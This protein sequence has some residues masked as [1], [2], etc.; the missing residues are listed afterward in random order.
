MDPMKFDGFMML[1]NAD[2]SFG[3]PPGTHRFFFKNFQIH[4]CYT[5]VDISG[6][7]GTCGTDPI[8][9]EGFTLV[10]VDISVGNPG[11]WSI[12]N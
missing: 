5:E 6:T 1:L 4:Y 3:I 10:R 12:S 9:F 2:K 7:L 8:K 11:G